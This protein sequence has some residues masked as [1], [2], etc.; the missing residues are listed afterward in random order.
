M[1]LILQRDICWT[2]STCVKC[3]VVKT[4]QFKIQAGNSNVTH[5]AGFLRL[6][7]SLTFIYLPD[8]SLDDQVLMLM[9]FFS[10]DKL[11]GV[12]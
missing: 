3:P 6:G 11:V 12:P 10:F 8:T 7:V 1:L 9:F 2:K 5:E 4:N